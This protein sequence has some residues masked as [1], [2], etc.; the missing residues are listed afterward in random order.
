MLDKVKK[1]FK[2]SGGV[3]AIDLGAS[4]VKILSCNIAG[5]RP[6]VSYATIVDYSKPVLS[7][8][9]IIE[10]RGF[11]EVME[12]V[13]RHIPENP[14]MVSFVMPGRFV[15]MH[16]FEVP[17]STVNL[18]SYVEEELKSTLPFPLEDI[19]YDTVV[20]YRGGERE[21]VCVITQKAVLQNCQNVILNMGVEDVVVDTAFTALANALV[22]NYPEEI[23]D[24][25]VVLLD[26]GRLNTNLVVVI[27]GFPTFG[28]CIADL[29][30]S[31]IDA[32]VAER[33]GVEISE[34]ERLKIDGMV[35]PDLIEE[36][37]K[38]FSSQLAGE[39]MALLSRINVQVVDKL[40]ITGGSS[41]LPSFSRWM[42]EHM[43]GQVALFNPFRRLSFSK[44][45]DR[46]FVE[47]ASG[48]FSLAVGGVIACISSERE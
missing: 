18:V 46:I 14:G 43:A 15:M 44:G 26:V 27:D 40:Y 21:V 7:V 47:E 45:V 3:T 24:S 5:K 34:A 29:S 42:K 19:V 2:R 41:I 30:G 35:D 22:Y 20:N 9:E 17:E 11:A 48:R 8:R 25:V 31:T 10:D 12:A 32:F 16:R 6:V 38:S 1:L 39:V 33:L 28:H 4:G 36:A 13:W 37:V 23:E